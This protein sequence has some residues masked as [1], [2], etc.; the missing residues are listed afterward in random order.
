MRGSFDE[1]PGAHPMESISI[2]VVH[3]HL[4]PDTVTL[5]IVGFL[6]AHT[7]DHLEKTLQSVLS[8]DR[9][10]LVFDLSETNYISSGGWAMI[11]AFLHRIRGDGGGLALTGMKP[12]VYDSYELLEFDK[13]LKSF[14]TVE[15]AL[16]DDFA[17][18]TGKAQK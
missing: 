18:P 1:G 9:K 13:V 6:Y 16:K 12:E 11:I 5:R 4:K 8:A 2:E 17:S 3:H 14:P 10:K 7:L 15:A